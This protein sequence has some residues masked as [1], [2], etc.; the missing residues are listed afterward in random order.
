MPSR[1]RRQLRA[2]GI[3]CIVICVMMHACHLVLVA[4]GICDPEAEKPRIEPRPRL[5]RAS[6]EI[7]AHSVGIND[8]CAK[9]EDSWGVSGRGSL[10]GS[11]EPTKAAG[12][13]R[14][15]RHVA[16]RC[17]QEFSNRRQ[18]R[19]VEARSRQEVDPCRGSHHHGDR[20]DATRA[21]TD[22]DRLRMR[23]VSLV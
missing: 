22:V 13:E 12:V 3:P 2:G 16:G 21:R 10:G 9:F 6:G 7:R 23:I 1:V 4:A 18:D 15:G 19:E 20:G 8:G 17:R 14:S 5:H 11:G